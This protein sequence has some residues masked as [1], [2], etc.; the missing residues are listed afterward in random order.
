MPRPEQ[1]G[2]AW[3]LGQLTVTAPSFATADFDFLPTT[4]LL[5]V[6][7][8]GGDG[9]FSYVLYLRGN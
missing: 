3:Q 5:R 1:D 9:F 8:Q 6:G 2:A 7:N 4:L